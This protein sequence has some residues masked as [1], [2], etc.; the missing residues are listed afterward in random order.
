MKSENKIALE[1]KLEN[2]QQDMIDLKNNFEKIKIDAGKLKVH[3][4]RIEKSL[5]LT[6]AMDQKKTTMLIRNM[7]ESDLKQ[8]EEE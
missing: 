5:L 8:E 4:L 7:I 6:V 2:I 3:L 1:K